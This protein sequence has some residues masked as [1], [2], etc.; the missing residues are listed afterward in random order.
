MCLRRIAATLCFAVVALLAGAAEPHH[1][2]I[3]WLVAGG[4]VATLM[5]GKP[6][7]LDA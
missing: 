5:F 6:G 3:G 1:L 4:D 2:H 7:R